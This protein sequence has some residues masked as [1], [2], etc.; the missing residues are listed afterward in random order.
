MCVCVCVC[1]CACVRVCVC[2]CYQKGFTFYFICILQMYGAQPDFSSDPG[3]DCITVNML[4]L[5]QTK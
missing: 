4:Y 5:K 3:K 2:V 1:V